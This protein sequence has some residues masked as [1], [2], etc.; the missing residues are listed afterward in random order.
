MKPPICAP[1]KRK[2][3][4]QKNGV[5]WVNMMAFTVPSNGQYPLGVTQRYHQAP[6]RATSCDRWRC[7]KCGNEILTGFAPGAVESDVDRFLSQCRKCGEE[8]VYEEV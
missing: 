1:C 8:I 4:V 6:Y 2:M 5:W 7:T 3:E